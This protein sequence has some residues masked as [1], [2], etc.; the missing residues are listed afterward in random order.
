MSNATTVY[1]L[2]TGCALAVAYGDMSGLN[3]E[4]TA[5]VVDFMADHG[6]LV[7]ATDDVHGRW[8]CECCGLGQL[9]PARTFTT[10]AA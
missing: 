8:L 2:C 1:Q 10:T 7:P 6:L 3:T 4:N 5:E 9:D